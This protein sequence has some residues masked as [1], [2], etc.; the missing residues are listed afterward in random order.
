MTNTPNAH[1]PHAPEE[2]IA[3]LDRASLFLNRE[4]SWLQFNLRV[5][6]EAENTSSPL[7][8]RVKFFTIFASNL[9]EF[10]MT[11]VSALHRQ[12]AAGVTDLPPDGMTPSE[13]MMAICREVTSQLRRHQACWHQ[14]LCPK[15]S[16]AGIHVLPSK[17]LSEAERLGLRDS[18][19]TEIFPVLTPLAIDPT[20]PFPHVSNLSFN[21]AVIVRDPER[22]EC[23]ARVKLPSGVKRLIPVPEPSPESRDPAVPGIVLRNLRFV[24]LEDV[25]AD[26]LDLLF[27]GLEIVASYA[28]RVTR[29]ADLTI[30]ESEAADLLT[31]VEQQLDLREFGSVI[32]LELDEEMPSAIADVLIAN[33]QLPPHLVYSGMRPIGVAG[34]AELMALDRPDLKD[35]FHVP[36]VPQLFAQSG[37]MLATIRQQDVLLFHPYDSFVPV[38]D[39]IREA[40]NDPAVLAIKQTLYRVGAKSPVVDALME[41]RM[42]GKQ[43]AVLV[44]LK[45]RFDEESNIEWARR[46]ED[47]GVHVVY[48]VRGLKTHAKM[49]LVIRREAEGIRRYVHLATGN[50]NIVSSRIYTD[51][52]YLTSDPVICNDVSDLFNALTGY[53]RKQ[54]YEK[55]LVAPKLLRQEVIERINR[56]IAHQ[57][58]GREGYLAFKMNALVD[59]ACIQ[60]L[61]RASQA[62]V[63]IDLQVRGICCLRP[64][65]KG[66]SDT[67][68]V[69]S[70]VGRFLEHARVYYFKNGGQEEVFVGSADLMPRNLD[71]RVEVLFPVANPLWRDVLVNEIIGVGI[72][73]NV[74]ARQL[75]PD[76]TYKRLH[77]SDGEPAIHS[78]EWFVTHWKSRRLPDGVIMPAISS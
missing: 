18:F 4:L 50:Y 70:V 30:K 75:S 69:I 14:D 44:E 40:A 56:E 66:L 42:N 59:K 12:I 7:L 65:V 13:Q 17:S 3:D 48:G 61:Y 58:A 62:G 68:R 20:H 72:R 6:E 16:S 78:Q 74:Q 8:E 26:N 38:V 49:C 77:P 41:A 15:L 22:G 55:L 25:V 23:F 29:D 2:T 43:V 76:G 57:R 64:G 73:D 71:Q 63:R 32:K 35:A 21:L 45:A 54:S 36:A 67:I 28:F 33:L 24:W 47:E 10:F 51:V 11:R 46:L 60:A 5:L 31:T 39:F 34:I 53:S 19:R 27:P 37:G 52:S 9:D 1:S